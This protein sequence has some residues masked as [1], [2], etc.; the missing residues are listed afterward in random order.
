M[1]VRVEKSKLQGSIS[2]SPSKSYTHRAVIIA[3]LCDGKSIIKNPL[4][5]RDT[6]A[7]INGCR[8][9]GAEISLD[10][11]MI[12]NGTFPLNNPKDIINVENS[13][14]TLRLL[15]GLSALSKKGYVILSGDE[16][17]RTRPMQPLLDALHGLGVRCWS[18][19][20]NGLAPIIV[21]GG[22]IYGGPVIISSDIS[23]QFISTL[24]IISP[25]ASIDTKI[26]LTGNCVSKPYILATKEVIEAF[27][28]K[29]SGNLT[30]TF[31]IHSFQKYIPGKFQVPGDFSSAAFILA[32][33]ILSGGKVKISGFDFKMPQGDAKIIEILQKIGASIIVDS[34]KGT[35][36]A[37]SSDQLNGGSFN[38]SDTPDLLPILAVVAC[39][40]DRKIR[41]TGVRHARFKETNRIAVL[42]SELP[43]LGVDVIEHDD[44]LTITGSKYL[45]Q[46]VL[47]AHSD[48][49]MA[50]AFSIIGMSS[51]EG[52]W[53]DGFQSTD[54]SYP[55]FREDITSLGGVIEG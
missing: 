18:T 36:T 33:A 13:G 42:A 49:R 50:M 9:L 7:S 5:S 47:N 45:N 40:S 51:D 27:G 39:K 38:L 15:T 34:E 1:K 48:H 12:V 3:S 32:G 8:S 6:L 55:R 11:D 30:D 17:A 54:V 52:C 28:V 53:I 26:S 25:Y 14:T 43:K 29:I 24:L 23:S 22:G 2:A 21:E 44:G 31:E 37:E 19:R 4:I 10:G 41:I 46:C 20:L 16:S 35:I